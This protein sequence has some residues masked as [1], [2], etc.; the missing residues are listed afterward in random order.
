VVDPGHDRVTIII[1]G[2]DQVERPER[3]RVI[4]PLGHDSAGQLPELVHSAAFEVPLVDV[5]GDVEIGVLDPVQRVALGELD[6]LGRARFARE[7]AGHQLPKLGDLQRPPLWLQNEQLQG[8]PGDG[9]RLEL[10][11]PSVV[12]GKLVA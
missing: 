2:S 3:S 6:S 8:M 1:E 5:C 10:E 11:E 4:E 9:I 12:D 7:T